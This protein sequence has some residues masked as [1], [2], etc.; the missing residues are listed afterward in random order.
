MN[1]VLLL[2]VVLL[3]VF[4][5]GMALGFILM[6]ERLNREASEHKELFDC[7]PKGL[8]EATRW[9]LMDVETEHLRHPFGGQA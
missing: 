2:I 1:L 3:S 6:G 4:M 8:S 9:Y 5:S 7:K